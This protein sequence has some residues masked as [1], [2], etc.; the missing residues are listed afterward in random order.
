MRRRTRPRPRPRTV[1]GVWC[2]PHALAHSM[3]RTNAQDGWAMAL[4]GRTDGRSMDRARI[5]QLEKRA[6]PCNAC[7]PRKLRDGH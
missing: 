2:G 4:D 7:M 3:E 6:E 5:Q 1:C